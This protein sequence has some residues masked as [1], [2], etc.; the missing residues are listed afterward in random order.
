MK[1]FYTVLQFFCW[2]YV[3]A[4]FTRLFYLS[5]TYHVD[6]VDILPGTILMF[7]LPAAILA[8]LL[9]IVKMQIKE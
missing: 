7:V 2:A 3:V 6:W 1:E 9:Q 4:G 8:T 5:D